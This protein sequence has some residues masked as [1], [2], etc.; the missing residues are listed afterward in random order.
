MDVTGYNQG[1]DAVAESWPRMIEL[2]E[3]PVGGDDQVSRTFLLVNYVSNE[4]HEK[5]RMMPNC[6]KVEFCV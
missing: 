1:R 3:L 5:F 2:V 6:N 4:I